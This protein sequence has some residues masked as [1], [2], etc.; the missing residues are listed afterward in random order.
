MVMGFLFGVMNILIQ[1]VW[2]MRSLVKEPPKYRALTSCAT[3]A[4]WPANTLEATELRAVKGANYVGCEIYL[5][6]AVI[7]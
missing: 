2:H 3:G 7:C 6:E 5:R 1:T 4:R